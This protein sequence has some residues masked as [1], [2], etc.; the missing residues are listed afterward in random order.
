ML[1]VLGASVCSVNR[2]ELNPFET[3]QNRRGNEALCPG[4]VVQLVAIDRETVGIVSKSGLGLY[5]FECSLCFLLVDV[6][7]N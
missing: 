4:V 7:A 3:S 6:D 5:P 2:P 1:A